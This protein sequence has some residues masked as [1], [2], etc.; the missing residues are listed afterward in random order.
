MNEPHCRVNDRG[1]CLFTL[2]VRKRFPSNLY[3]FVARGES[4]AFAADISWG[5]DA[6][7]HWCCNFYALLTL[8][9][10]VHPAAVFE[11]EPMLRWLEMMALLPQTAARSIQ[12]TKFSNRP[13]SIGSLSK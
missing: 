11:P 3:T 9:G 12:P 5:S 8:A 2:G 10:R 6:P 7:P 4:Y 1:P 13:E